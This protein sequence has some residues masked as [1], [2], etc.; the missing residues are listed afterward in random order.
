MMFG[1]STLFLYRKRKV[2]IAENIRN[3]IEDLEPPIKVWEILD[4]GFNKLANHQIKDLKELSSEYELKFSVHAPFSSI[5]IAESSEEIRR[6]FVNFLISSLRRAYE[7]EAEAFVLH[8]GRLTPFTF[9]FPELAKEASFR[10]LE[11]L[12]DEAENLGIKLF[13]E[14][15]PL[16]HELINTV[17]SAELFFKESDQRARFC[18]DTGHAN[19]FGDVSEFIEKLRDKLSYIHIHDN[20]GDE[21]SHLAVGDGNIDWEKTASLLKRI[22]YEGW[23]IL[24]NLSIDDLKRSFERLTE[25]FEA[26]K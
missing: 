5:N 10:S 8:P 15:M 18:L 16:K 13:A 1:A 14:N 19:L 20:F 12:L 24:E 23:I 2:S 21:D 3:L 22:N 7:I 6:F 26:L 9:S 11:E 4:E 17:E 25:L